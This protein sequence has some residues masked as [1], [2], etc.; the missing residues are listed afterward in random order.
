MIKQKAIIIHNNDLGRV[1]EIIVKIR[2]EFNVSVTTSISERSNQTW[3]YITRIESIEDKLVYQAITRMEEL[4]VAE[5]VQFYVP[6]V[7]G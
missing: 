1:G 3:L 5:Y 2:A 7:V 6:Q 4:L